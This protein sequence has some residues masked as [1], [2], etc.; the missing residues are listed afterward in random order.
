MDKRLQEYLGTPE[1]REKLGGIARTMARGDLDVLRRQL[2]PEAGM[3]SVRL[4]RDSMMGQIVKEAIKAIPRLE[5]GA[6]I[7]TAMQY[8]MDCGAQATSGGFL[9]AARAVV[10]RTTCSGSPRD[11]GAIIWRRILV[12]ARE[13][14]RTTLV[15]LD[16][17]SLHT[18]ASRANREFEAYKYIAEL[19][20]RNTGDDMSQ[21]LRELAPHLPAEIRTIV[22]LGPGIRKED[23]LKEARRAIQTMEQNFPEQGRSEE[24]ARMKRKISDLEALNQSL[25]QATGKRGRVLTEEGL[26]NYMDEHLGKTINKHFGP[27]VGAT[28]NGH[29]QGQGRVPR[30]GDWTCSSCGD[31]AFAYR[32]KCR[33]CGTPKPGQVG[34]PPP[35]P[36]M[37]PVPPGPPPSLPPGHGGV[38]L[39]KQP[40]INHSRGACRTPSCPRSHAVA[41]IEPKPPTGTCAAWWYGITCTRVNCRYEHN[42]RKP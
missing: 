17:E 11:L 29:Q 36:P 22:L 10:S 1:G 15:K 4:S 38:P 12:A 7:G 28:E 23:R 6:S 39:G 27:K 32:S 24:A 9:M 31:H 35:M 30:A 13:A 2:Q 16:S 5:G 21:F 25:R 37:P 3:D 19:R 20:G 41:D 26:V 34:P 14:W 40:C 42:Q 18:F 33:R 8:V